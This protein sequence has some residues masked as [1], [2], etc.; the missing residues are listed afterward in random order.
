MDLMKGYYYEQ[1]V[2]FK[3]MVSYVYNRGCYLYNGAAQFSG[4]L[5]EAEKNR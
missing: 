4:P 3:R 5:G 1:A 2:C